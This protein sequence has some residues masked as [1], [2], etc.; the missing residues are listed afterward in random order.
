[1]GWF[2]VGVVYGLRGSLLD[3]YKYLLS[4][5]NI[6]INRMEQNGGNLKT[7]EKK[8]SRK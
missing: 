5:Q 1:M 8:M 3:L 6:K 2:F 4:Y 7:M